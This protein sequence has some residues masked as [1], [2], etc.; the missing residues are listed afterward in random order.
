MILPVWPLTLS[1]VGKW[2]FL[3][4]FFVAE[5]V[6]ICFGCLPGSFPQVPVFSFFSEGGGLPP[7]FSLT[8]RLTAILLCFYVLSWTREQCPSMGLEGFFPPRP[9]SW[10]QPSFFVTFRA[11][12]TFT[13]FACPSGILFFSSPSH[14][15]ALPLLSTVPFFGMFWHGLLWFS[16]SS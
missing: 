3:L 6:R 5:P 10:P 16:F 2:C 8:P 1:L 7:F 9:T 12:G 13:V 14:Q 11:A 15:P 4:F